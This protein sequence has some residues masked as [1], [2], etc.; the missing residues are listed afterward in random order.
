MTASTSAPS[1][2]LPRYEEASVRDQ[3]RVLMEA[4]GASPTTVSIATDVMYDTD[5]SGIDSHGISMLPH[6]AQAIRDGQLDAAADPRV[7]RDTGAVVLVDGERGFGHPAG[8]LAMT[9]AIAKAR[10]FGV[11]TANVTR[12]NHYG[13]AGYYA[14]M[15]AEQGLVGL[16][17]CSTKYALQTPTGA[18]APLMGT[19]PIA[20]ACPVAGEEPVVVDMSTSVVPLNKVKV[21]DLKDA[22]LPADWVLDDTG[23]PVHDAAAAM[24]GL[25]AHDG[26]HGLLPLGGAGVLGGG[27]KGYALATMVQLL[28]AGLAGADQPGDTEGYQSIGYFF[29]AIDPEIVN[30]GGVT[31]A[32]AKELRDTLRGMDPVDPDR[33]VQVAGDPEHAERARRR[34][35]GIP[36]SDSLVG[37]I[38]ALCTDFSAP[39]VLREPSGPAGGA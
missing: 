2:G 16:S 7:V 9:E 37:Q 15:A 3:I 38:R 6:Y 33:P 5:L 23:T 25:T 27:H 34:V 12:T 8:H 22:P 30:P 26:S 39:E 19:N 24:A 20:F 32:Y 36:L 17:V 1:T 11:G 14:R 28:G 21:Y 4:F 31:P 10:T 29:L 35:E 18:R 13:A